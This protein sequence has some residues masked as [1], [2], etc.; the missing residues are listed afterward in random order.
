MRGTALIAVIVL[1]SACRDESPNHSSAGAALRAANAQYD[2]ALIDGDAPALDRF[3]AD[4]FKIISDDAEISDKKEQIRFMTEEVDLLEARSD[5]VHLTMLGPDS[6]LMTGR[7]TGRYSY[8]GQER[9]FV[10]RYTAIWV[11]D[12]ENWRLKHEHSS[13][14]PEA[15]EKRAVSIP[16]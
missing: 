16:G 14:Q 11:R 15:A 1:L 5:D 4:D 6:A 9:D 13:I 7:F 10:E 3:Y 8:K 2:R 12:G